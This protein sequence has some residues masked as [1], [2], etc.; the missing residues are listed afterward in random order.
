MERKTV[1]L[2][3]EKVDRLSAIAKNKGGLCQAIWEYS[4]EQ[5]GV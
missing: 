3:Q 2:D 1:Q 5:Y 4:Q